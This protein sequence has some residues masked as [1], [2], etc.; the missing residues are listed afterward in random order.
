M[1]SKLLHCTTLA[2]PVVAGVVNQASYELSTTTRD[3]FTIADVYQVASK[4]RAKLGDEAEYANRNLR[5]M[6]GHA[7][8][9]DCKLRLLSI[10]NDINELQPS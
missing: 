3:D 1:P 4:A 7:N 5:R 6:V 2:D 10:S 8:L 9:L